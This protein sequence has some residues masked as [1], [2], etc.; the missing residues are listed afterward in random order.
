MGQIQ[1]GFA[2]TIAICGILSL[3]CG[4]VS[5]V[6]GWIFASK[7]PDDFRFQS[8]ESYGTTSYSFGVYWWGGL[9]LFVPGI[10]GIVV[11][12]TRNVCAMVAFLIFNIIG[13]L[14]SIACVVVVILILVVWMA[15]EINDNSCKSILNTCTCVVDDKRS[16]T[17]NAS[18]ET[19]SSLQPLLLAIIVGVALSG[20]VAF[21]ASYVSCCSL[22]N[23]EQVYPGMVVVRQPPNMVVMANTQFNQVP[24]APYYNQQIPYGGLPPVYSSVPVTSYDHYPTNDKAALIDNGVV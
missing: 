6:C 19:L 14:A 21:I 5:T 10:L 7:I 9:A 2:L 16:F 8:F 23:T 22:C 4:F 11:A 13:M 20:F 17:M 1:K 12:C 15:L 3:L 24:Q 18:C